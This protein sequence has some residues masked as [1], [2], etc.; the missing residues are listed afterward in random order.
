MANDFKNIVERWAEELSSFYPLPNITKLQKELNKLYIKLRIC[1]MP[2]DK[3]S[4]TINS[5]LQKHNIKKEDILSTNTKPF[6]RAD[7]P[8]STLN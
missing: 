1:G 2:A 3:V 5:L 6:Q 8:K 7:G 4:E